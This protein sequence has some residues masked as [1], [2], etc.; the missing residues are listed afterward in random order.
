LKRIIKYL[1]NVTFLSFLIIGIYLSYAIIVKVPNREKLIEIIWYQADRVTLVSIVFI[2]ITTYLNFLFER[3]IEKKQYSREFF[4]L[5]FFHFLI[6]IL[7]FAYFSN[8]FYQEF[9]L[10][11]EYF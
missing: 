11:P 10:H 7:A 9:M 2:I 5:S 8:N 3:K 6:L 1:I 4:I